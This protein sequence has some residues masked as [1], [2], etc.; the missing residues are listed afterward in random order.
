MALTTRRSSVRSDST[1]AGW[2]RFIHCSNSTGVAQAMNVA[3]SGGMNGVR[4]PTRE[5]VTRKG[6]G[7]PAS[8]STTRLLLARTM[9]V[10]T[11]PNSSARS[12]ITARAGPTA[13][14]RARAALPRASELGPS[15]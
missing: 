5:S 13:G 9:T 12:S 15:E 11:T 7:V 14:N 4:R 2:A 6:P 8:V 10:H 3:P 1:R